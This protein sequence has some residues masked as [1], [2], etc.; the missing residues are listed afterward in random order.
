MFL[1]LIKRKSF[2]SSS[3]TNCKKNAISKKFNC[4]RFIENKKN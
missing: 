1:R 2:I 4:K 3:E